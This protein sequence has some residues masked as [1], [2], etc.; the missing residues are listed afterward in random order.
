MFLKRR[1]SKEFKQNKKFKYTHKQ[2]TTNNSLKRIDFCKFLDLPSDDEEAIDQFFSKK[3]TYNEITVKNSSEIIFEL[4]KKIGITFKNKLLLHQALKHYAGTKLLNFSSNQRLEFIGDAVLDYVIAHYIFNTYKSSTKADLVKIHFSIVE[5]T[6]LQRIAHDKLNLTSYLQCH[7]KPKILSDT[8]EAIIGAILCDQGLESVKKFVYKFILERNEIIEENNSTIHSFELNE[9]EKYLGIEFKQKNLLQQAITHKSV[10]SEYNYERLEFLGAYVLK[11][12]LSYYAF[13]KNSFATE[14]ECTSIV[15]K[16]NS[17]LPIDDII[18]K[19]V[20][21]CIPGMS[22]ESKSYENIATS[23][24]IAIIGAICVDKGGI[25][26]NNEGEYDVYNQFVY[27]KLSLDENKAK[28]LAQNIQL[29]PKTQLQ[30]FL[31][32]EFKIPY[33]KIVYHL[34][35]KD[36]RGEKVLFQVYCEICKV[37]CSYGWGNTKKQAETNAAERALIA[38]KKVLE[39]NCNYTNEQEFV[40]KLQEVVNEPSMK[41]ILF[42][43]IQLQKN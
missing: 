20:K 31:I 7:I 28:F 21:Q 18:M 35:D 23:V 4:E 2:F 9:L 11:F 10:S 25:F 37:M 27:K 12:I 14:S 42:K 32:K 17:T 13:I 33:E 30:Q 22:K 41:V 5:N 16:I 8:L 29:P 15:S 19:Y 24:L 39:I 6:N 40:K 38:L 43:P 3:E 34:I 1:Q 26:K 36:G